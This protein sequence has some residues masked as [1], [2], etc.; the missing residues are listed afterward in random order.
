M[1]GATREHRRQLDAS[2]GISSARFPKFVHHCGPFFH[3]LR[4]AKGTSK[5]M[6]PEPLSI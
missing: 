4:K 3:E 1:A 5:I 6:I 2:I